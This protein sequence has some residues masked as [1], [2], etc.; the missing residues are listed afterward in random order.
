MF[1]VTIFLIV[2]SAWLMH[3]IWLQNKVLDLEARFN[4]SREID[5]KLMNFTHDWIRSI[6]RTMPESTVAEIQQLNLQVT[7]LNK[8]V[9]AL[10]K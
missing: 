3:T 9:E 6:K 1:K 7:E 8:Q 2:F 4:V 5:K 10:K